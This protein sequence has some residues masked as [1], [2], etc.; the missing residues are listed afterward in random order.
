MIWFNGASFVTKPS[1]LVQPCSI[2]MLM[3]LGAGLLALLEPDPPA[4]DDDDDLELLL[5]QAARVSVAATAI[6]GTANRQRPARDE[7]FMGF[8][9][10]MF[11]STQ[12]VPPRTARHWFR[13][14]RAQTPEHRV[15]FERVL[16]LSVRRAGDRRPVVNA[17][18]TM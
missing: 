7:L 4:D 5:P 9:F 12:A 13:K 11:G 18:K 3:L 16:G 14:C 17:Q 1:T 10:G 2:T 15:E 6:A 8:P